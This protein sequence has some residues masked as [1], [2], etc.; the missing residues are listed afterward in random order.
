MEDSLAAVRSFPE[1]FKD[2]L[3]I[4]LY[5]A[6]L[7]GKHIKAKL[8][9]HLSPGVLEA[10]FRLSLRHLLRCVYLKNSEPSVCASCLSEEVEGRDCDAKGRNRSREATAQARD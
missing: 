5:Y 1:A 4:E 6:Q 9:H 2:E 3:G 7:D 8:L 10:V